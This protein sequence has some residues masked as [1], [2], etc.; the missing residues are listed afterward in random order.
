MIPNVKTVIS[1]IR[2]VAAAEIMPRFRNL[3]ADDVAAKGSPSDL[4]TTADI[5]AERRLSAALM[6]L[7]PGSAVIGEEAAEHDPTVFAAFAGTSPVWLVDPVD[8]TRNFAHDKPCFAVIVAYCLG[9]ETVAGWIHD[10]VA[11]ATVWAARGGGAWIEDAAGERPIRAAAPRDLER[12]TGS[13]GWRLARRIKA[14]RES[15]LTMPGRIVRYGCVGR[16][17]MDLAGGALDFALYTRLKPWDH[18]AGVLI[19]REA[20]GFSRITDDLTPY[21]PAPGIQQ[22]TLLLAPDEAA[23]QALDA[24]FA[25]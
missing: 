19:H 16:E 10:P 20:G 18:A 24:A 21:R 12:M 22:T 7:R 15:G 9:G 8:G 5:E 11:D 13:L 3:G 1:I 17:Y 14:Q 6:R 2:E 23:W 25:T 4:V